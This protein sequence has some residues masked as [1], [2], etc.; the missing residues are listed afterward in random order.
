MKNASTRSIKLNTQTKL[1]QCMKAKYNKSRKNQFI[2]HARTSD[3]FEVFYISNLYIQYSYIFCR[4][5][6]EYV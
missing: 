5:D 1:Q 2:N 4:S 3:L 6:I